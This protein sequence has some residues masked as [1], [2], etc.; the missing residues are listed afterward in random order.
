MPFHMPKV[1]QDVLS[2][3]HKDAVKQ[4][5]EDYF[6]GKENKKKEDGGCSFKTSKKY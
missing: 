3:Y 2:S 5:Y 6:T 1:N 4:Q